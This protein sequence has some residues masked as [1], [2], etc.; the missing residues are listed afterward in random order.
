MAHPTIER[1]SLRHQSYIEPS[2][3][4]AQGGLDRR[5]SRL[6][7]VRANR[8]RSGPQALGAKLLDL[9]TQATIDDGCRARSVRSPDAL[10]GPALIADS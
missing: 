7:P 10:F 3:D 1:G 6:A 8:H 4:H 2:S 5:P 9:G